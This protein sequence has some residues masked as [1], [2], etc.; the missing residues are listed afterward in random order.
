MELL[1]SNVDEW[2]MEK[3]LLLLPLLVYDKYSS[4][5]FENHKLVELRK[6]ITLE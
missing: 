3:Y 2:S 1:C 6:K 4:K 5:L